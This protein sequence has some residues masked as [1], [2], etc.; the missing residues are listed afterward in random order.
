MSGSMDQKG[1]GRPRKNKELDF[2]ND[3]DY[4]TNLIQNGNSELL[5]PMTNSTLLVETPNF[6]EF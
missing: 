5:M 1:P 3:F 6:Y 4:A 2:G